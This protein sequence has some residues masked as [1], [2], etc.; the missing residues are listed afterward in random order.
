MSTHPVVKTGKGAFVA[1]V[2]L[3]FVALS[4]CGGQPTQGNTQPANTTP[5]RIGYS[6]SLG[7]DFAEDGKALKLGYEMWR[8]AVNKR[9]G[10]LGRQVE[11]I[12]Y[13]DN[14]DPKLVTT[15]YQKLMGTDKVDLVLGPFS[16]LLN[17]S[18]IPVADRFNYA[19]M[20]GAA[21][22]EKVFGLK[23]QHFFSASPPS[24]SYLGT[25]A[26]FLLSLPQGQ[27]P[28]T[29]AY[30][31][32]DDP[33]AVPQVQYGKQVLTD[34]GVKAVF[35]NINTPFPAEQTDVSAIAKQI[36][37]SNAD[38]VVLGT[39]GVDISVNFIKTFRQQHYQPKAIIATSGPDEGSAFSSAI[40]IATTEGVFVPNA[41][42]FPG[43]KNYQNDQF[44]ADWLA[45][46]P[47]KTDQDINNGTVQGY[48]AGQVLE[49]AV[50]KAKTLDQAKL[51]SEL[52]SDSFDS[53]QG[54]VKFGPDGRNTLGV[55]FLFQWQSGK[56]IPVYPTN[57][58][59][60]NPEYP[61]K[62]W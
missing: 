25:F 38:V 54:P 41:G 37:Q 9:G 24:V 22:G 17:A 48:S 62:P 11:L 30:V 1:L 18:A 12:S 4:A 56:L 31:T 40:G 19:L 8:D 28:T 53:L 13:D 43:I 5:I 23:S 21:T 51:V 27:R 42:W 14:S 26:Q 34:G 50:T 2:M 60:A 58:A 36:I 7:G 32:V 15:N 16:T 6:V 57:Q 10:L 59:Q 47:G 44:E 20:A 46:N 35:D 45:K 61:K 39:V 33:F 55:P 3:A 29:A 49:Q 52:Q